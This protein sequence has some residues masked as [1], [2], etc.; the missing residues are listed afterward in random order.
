MRLVDSGYQ[1][2]GLKTRPVTPRAFVDSRSAVGKGLRAS[3]SI[4][5]VRLSQRY[6]DW[7]P[8][9][10]L[11]SKAAGTIGKKP[12]LSQRFREWQARHRAEFDVENQPAC[13]SR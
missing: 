9:A 3:K 13:F 6:R 12:F 7:A 11:N 4:I 10:I 8:K 1:R 2:D 5:A